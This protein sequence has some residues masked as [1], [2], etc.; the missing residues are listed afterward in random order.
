MVTTVNAGFE[1]LKSNL[2]I[3]NLQQSAG[4]NRQKNIRDLIA[5][6]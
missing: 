4:S 3:T 6:D 2:E 1:I 5:K